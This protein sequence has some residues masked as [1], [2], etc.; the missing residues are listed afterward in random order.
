MCGKR[1][2]LSVLMFLVV[3]VSI[4]MPLCYGKVIEAEGYACDS[5]IEVAKKKALRQ[6]RQ[7]AVEEYVGVL[8]DSRVLVVNG[9]L[10]RETIQTM[11]LGKVR[12]IGNPEFFEE[13]IH[14]QENVICIRA[15]A[16]FE[17]KKEDFYRR[18]FGLKLVLNKKE[19]KPGE[20]L[21][22][23]LYAREKCYPYLFSVDAE[24]RV[25]RLLPNH[26]KK[27]PVLQG[28]LVFPT[29]RMKSAGITLAVFP[30]PK[31][32]KKVQIEEMLFIC[33]RKREESLK[34]L[35]PEAFATSE[36]EFKKLVFQPFGLKVEALSQ[37]LEQIGLSNYEMIDDFYRIYERAKKQ[38]H[39]F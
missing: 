30:N 29:P 21:R 27:D 3:S 11:A 2:L 14:L 15:K 26:I 22:L 31:L 8:V 16:K 35:F 1:V 17:V 6:A 10:M 13:K 19:F 23:S 20:E 12:L 25:Y 39:G 18:N 5:N 36:E 38:K 24:G 33:T 32:K 34:E 28:K 9:K 4:W 37:V 7:R